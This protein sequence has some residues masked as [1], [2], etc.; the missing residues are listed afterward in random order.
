[1]KLFVENTGQVIDLSRTRLIADSGI[2]RHYDSEGYYGDRQTW[3]YQAGDT[4]Y[5]VIQD[6]VPRTTGWKG[7]LDRG[8]AVVHQDSDKRC[9][10][11]S[12]RDVGFMLRMIGWSTDAIEQFQTK[13]ASHA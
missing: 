11:R 12:L 10:E 5:E 7:V 2:K 9:Y 8:N 13:E 1:M 6:Y 4:F 3:L